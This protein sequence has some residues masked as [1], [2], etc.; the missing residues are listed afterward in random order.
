MNINLEIE[1]TR[2]RFNRQSY[3]E[4]PSLILIKS[5]DLIITTERRNGLIFYSYNKSSEFEF[6]IC[7]QNKIIQIM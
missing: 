2:P 3:L 7:I 4:F 1:I 6:I 5:I